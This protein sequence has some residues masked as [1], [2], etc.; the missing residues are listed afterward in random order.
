MLSTANS[1]GYFVMPDDKSIHWRGGKGRKRIVEALLCSCSQLTSLYARAVPL[2][3][4]SGGGV[5]GTRRRDVPQPISAVGHSPRETFRMRQKPLGA[6]NRDLHLPLPRTRSPSISHLYGPRDLRWA[7]GS[8]LRTPRR[9]NQT[10]QPQ[11]QPRLCLACA[12][13]GLASG[14]GATWE[15]PRATLAED[16]AERRKIGPAKK[17]TVD[18]SISYVCSFRGTCGPQIRPRTSGQ[19]ARLKQSA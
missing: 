7:A 6:R 12:S 15:M 9:S 2:N 1:A 18:L 16:Q 3:R 8:V 17:E 4:T 11:L 10:R 5:V 19:F 13:P 14:L